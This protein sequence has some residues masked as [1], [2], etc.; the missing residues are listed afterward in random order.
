LELGKV[1]QS[2]KHISTLQ[3]NLEEKDKI[4]DKMKTAGSSLKAMFSST[5]QKMKELKA[6]RVTMNNELQT[7]QDQL[8]NLK[9][10]TVPQLELDESLV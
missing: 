7:I 4:I 6:E 2:A 8:R 1:S 3:Q 9:S 5:Q 10:F